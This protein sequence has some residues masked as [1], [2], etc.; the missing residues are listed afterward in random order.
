[1]IG[2]KEIVVAECGGA[3]PEQIAN[4]DA[5]VSTRKNNEE[6]KAVTQMA[7]QVKL[8][9]GQS[10]KTI[11]N[12]FLIGSLNKAMLIAL[13]MYGKEED[14]G[15]RPLLLSAHKDVLD[16]I[17]YHYYKPFGEIMKCRYVVDTGP[18]RKS[19]TVTLPNFKP[20]E[21][22]KPP[23]QATH[24]QFCLSVGAV[25]DIVYD[26]DYERYTPVYNNIRMAQSLKEMES[27]WIP[28]NAKAMGDLTYS[29]TLPEGFI[30]ADDMT[31]V[32]TF[33]IVFGKMTSEV[34]P[35]KRDRGGIDFLGAV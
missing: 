30:L 35:L 4:N 16:A 18:D 7:K 32:R 24:F 8:H 23:D 26:K 9:F 31:V 21:Q 15:T 25:S 27:E 14:R 11:V 6:W 33:G 2:C 13:R 12:T 29:V 20:K 22:I 28:I 34:E 3:T 17:T 19:V 1:L 5:F 10:S